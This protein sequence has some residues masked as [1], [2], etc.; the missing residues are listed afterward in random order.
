RKSQ[1]PDQAHGYKQESEDG[2]CVRN[3]RQPRP[4]LL[5]IHV[6][7]L[8]SWSG[9]ALASTKLT[10]SAMTGS[11]TSWTIERVGIFG[12]IFLSCVIKEAKRADQ[13]N[14]AMLF[15]HRN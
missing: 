4:R 12:I 11:Q 15:R 9:N 14:V 1:G 13:D 7:L 10:T 3:T 6:S 8:R 2:Q 5:G